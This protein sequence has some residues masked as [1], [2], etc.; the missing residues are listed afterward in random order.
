MTNNIELQ[1]LKSR[2]PD[3]FKQIS[4]SLLE[5]I[6]SEE[7]SSRISKICLESGLEDEEKI[8]KIAYRVTLALLDQVPKENLTE[9]FEKGVKLD[10][11]TA[12]KISIEI[13]LNIFS[14][15]QK[16]RSKEIQK[17]EGKIDEDRLTQPAN[18]SLSATKKI[19]SEEFSEKDTYQE[20]IE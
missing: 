8:G 9:I 17:K 6:F 14:Q 12:K 16:P 1:K 13:K 18:P 15:I 11:E 4:P 19:E 2:Y 7:T 5:F 20:P 10:H 3:F